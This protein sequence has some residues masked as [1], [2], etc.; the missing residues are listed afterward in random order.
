V[1][2][3]AYS[4]RSSRSPPLSRAPLSVVSRHGL[5][6]RV[7]C[8]PFFG[9]RIVD[10]RDASFSLW[11]ATSWLIWEYSFAE[12][13]M[14]AVYGPRTALVLAHH[15]R[16]GRQICSNRTDN[17]GLRWSLYACRSAP[18]HLVGHGRLTRFRSSAA[19]AR[20][21]TPS[22]ISATPPDAGRTSR[23]TRARRF[24]AQPAASSPLRP[25]TRQ[26]RISWK[27]NSNACE[28]RTIKNY[29]LFELRWRRQRR[30]TGAVNP[31]SGQARWDVVE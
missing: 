27:T 19:R 23:S 22:P 11:S 14:Y 31:S 24:G 3:L 30:V 2:Q 26:S 10:R 4:S 20:A 7:M 5:A 8:S 12:F 6:L 25:S 29:H 9:E 15:V 21:L 1:C 28:A 16:A 13:E 18:Y 17:S